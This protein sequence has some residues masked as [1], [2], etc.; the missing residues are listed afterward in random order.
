MSKVTRTFPSVFDPQLNPFPL[1]APKSANQSDILTLIMGAFN[2][3]Q[4]LSREGHKESTMIC[5]TEVNEIDNIRDEV[6]TYEI[7]DPYV[8]L[9]GNEH[10]GC[11]EETSRNGVVEKRDLIPS[12]RPPSTTQ[13]DPFPTSDA[14]RLTA[15]LVAA[16]LLLWFILRK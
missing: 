7:C 1:S 5:H 4:G 3:K 9:D 10:E 11:H 15:V 12:T 13:I 16:A 6:C 8:D 2:S 14:I